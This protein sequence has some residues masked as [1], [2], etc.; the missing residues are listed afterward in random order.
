MKHF[1]LL[2][3]EMQDIVL[4]GHVIINHKI[5]LHAFGVRVDKSGLS[6]FGKEGKPLDTRKRL[7]VDFYGEAIQYF[8]KIASDLVK[9]VNFHDI[10]FFMEFW[11]DKA[12]NLRK[13]RKIP[14]NRF[15][16]SYAKEN[17]K[18][19]PPNV[20]V[21]DEFAEIAQ[22]DPP[23]IV[24]DGFLK[25]EQKEF[26]FDFANSTE[27]FTDFEQL[28]LLF[29]KEKEY[30]E[31]FNFEGLVL[32][33]SYENNW[34][35]VKIVDP[36]YTEN[37]V[38]KSK[39]EKNVLIKERAEIFDPVVLS[40]LEEY[41]YY[42]KVS[43]FWEFFE[44][45]LKFYTD[46]YQNIIEKIEVGNVFFDINYDMV[47]KRILNL[48][49]NKPKLKEL[50]KILFITFTAKGGLRKSDFPEKSY[51]IIER[52]R[53]K[54]NLMNIPE[55]P[56]PEKDF[57]KKK[58]NDEDEKEMQKLVSTDAEKN[59]KTLIIGRFQPPHIGHV[60][61]TTK[62]AIYDPVYI[63][64]YS[65]NNPRS[66]FPPDLII[67]AFEKF[68]ERGYLPENTEFVVEKTGYL[69]DIIKEHDWTVGQII[70]GDDRLEGYIKQF[71][72][73]TDIIFTRSIRYFR[74]EN[75]REWLTDFVKN[76]DKILQALNNDDILYKWYVENIVPVLTAS[77]NNQF[78]R[79]EHVSKL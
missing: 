9:N 14:K 18:L 38:K 1:K 75:F 35:A 27:S 51:E 66:P 67:A 59:M 41:L 71:P 12:D 58:D 5:D 42:G 26:L 55:P 44:K 34:N 57:E 10:T 73:N 53:R 60:Y 30:V 6:Y 64:V 52:L 43:E 45:T 2:S 62:F 46:H 19:I 13:P 76:K 61:M 32:Y 31:I 36:K 70:A 78:R 33:Y 77:E 21:L 40:A 17:K 8:E 37:I 79:V 11:N 23:P 74:G 68:K 47:D 56:S 65:E 50:F 7:L 22:I 49:E 20:S 25:E 72:E 15:I 48:I 24:W 16:L 69:P 39:T 28:F 63:I 3:P 54:Y 4:N 29:P